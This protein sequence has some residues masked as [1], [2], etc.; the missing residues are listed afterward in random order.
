MGPSHQQCGAD[1]A[2]DDVEQ[3]GFGADP[4]AAAAERRGGG[5]RARRGGGGGEKR[6]NNS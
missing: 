6:R 1:R 3:R 5:G 4:A 2:V